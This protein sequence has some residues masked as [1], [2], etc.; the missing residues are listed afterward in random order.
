MHEPHMGDANECVRSSK[1]LYVYR[2]SKE[3][4]QLFFY[5]PW[6]LETHWSCSRPEEVMELIA[7]DMKHRLLLNFGNY[8][9]HR[10]LWPKFELQKLL[11]SMSQLWAS[12]RPHGPN[13]CLFGVLRQ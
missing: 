1:R 4:K 3:S 9:W 6:W 2:S 7:P 11:A 13:K 10:L 5:P 12:N 8:S